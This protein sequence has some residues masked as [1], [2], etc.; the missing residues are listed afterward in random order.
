MTY[1]A[2]RIVLGREPGEWVVQQRA[3][4]PR[5]SYGLLATDL[6][7]LLKG[8]DER[9]RAEFTKAFGT[10]NRWPERVTFETMRAWELIGLDER[11]QVRHDEGRPSEPT[12]PPAPAMVEIP[13]HD[14]PPA[15]F[16]PPAD[17]QPSA[18]A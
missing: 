7:A 17:F 11:E 6:S 5:P 16:Q 14:I 3:T 4:T 9:Q 18:D 15:I 2:A 8:A 1:A 10:A 12:E 13:P